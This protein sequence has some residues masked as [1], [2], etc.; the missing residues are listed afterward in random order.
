MR[1]NYIQIT[2]QILAV[3]CIERIAASTYV[4]VHKQPMQWWFIISETH[5]ALTAQL[6]ATLSGTMQIGALKSAHQTLFLEYLNSESSNSPKPHPQDKKG[7]QL[8]GDIASF[9]VLIGRALDPEFPFKS[10]TLPLLIL[11]HA[12]KADINR[13][14]DFRNDLAHVQ[15]TNWSLEIGGL[16]RIARA[17]VSAIGQLF[18]SSS[19][20]LHLE[21][22]D[23]L[24][25][26]ASLKIILQILE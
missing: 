17:A 8:K 25:M 18:E 20:R 2:P 26:E 7:S 9:E 14:H 19:Q 13:L 15:P 3:E 22:N 10:G 4:A 23:I 12:D 21:E 16:P 6:V 11:N 5:L 24:R 1:E